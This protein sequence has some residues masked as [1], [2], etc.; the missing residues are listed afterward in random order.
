MAEPGE[1]TRLIAV[2]AAVCALVVGCTS[3]N[4][5]EL[6]PSAD[7]VV[8]ADRVTGP[9]GRAFL[10]EITTA[11]WDDGGQRAA[12]IF[13]WIPRDATSADPISATQAGQ[14]AHAIASF[15]ADDR[16]AVR[17][18]PANSALWQSF[19]QSLIPYLGAATGDAASTSGFEPLD[20]VD[21]KM[22][23][24]TSLFAAMTEDAE[25]N[26]T[27]TT[28][29]AELA[30][31][32]ENAFAEAVVAQPER[33]SGG[34]ALE[35]LL[36]AARLRAL[37]DAGRY[38]ADPDS[39]RPNP[40]R[41]QTEV[42]YQVAALT[43]RPD[44]PHINNEFFKDGRLLPPAEIPD[45]DWSIYDAQLSTYLVAFPHTRPAIEEFVHKYDVIAD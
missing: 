21:S 1:M 11:A 35:G 10:R 28:A 45:S 17:N 25:A 12:A 42:M 38:L 33:L 41:A 44:D 31:R 20:D 3:H 18:A 36:Q 29:A 37:I 5:P 14:T 9:D 40:R 43:A 2:A 30:Q 39:P 23:R 7:T 24:T 27:F 34:G 26:R 13:A 16:D 19:S 22:N 6:P 4:E 8:V 32:N 15:L